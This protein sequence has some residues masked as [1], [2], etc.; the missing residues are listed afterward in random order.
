MCALVCFWPFFNI[1]YAFSAFFASIFASCMVLCSKTSFGVPYLSP[2]A[3][4]DREGMKD[5]LYMA[6]L[7]AMRRVPASLTGKRLIRTKGRIPERK[8][9]KSGK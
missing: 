9:M 2:F 3:P 7:W 4:F 1:R 8:G 6:P 5:F